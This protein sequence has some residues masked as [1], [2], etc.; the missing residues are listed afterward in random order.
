IDAR[1]EP[2]ALDEALA[3]LDEYLDYRRLAAEELSDPAL[4][5]SADLERRFQWI[6]ELRRRSFGAERAEALFAAEEEAVR[7]RLEVERVR[8]DETLEPE[9]RRRRLAELEARYPGPMRE[10]RAR[11]VSSLDWSRHEEAMRAQGF[12]PAEIHAAREARFGA[13]AAERM[14]ALDA[15]RADWAA[16]LE[17]YRQE[18]DVLLES[19]VDAEDARLAIDALRRRHFTAEEARRVEILDGA[20]TE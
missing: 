7:V 2:P 11:A 14:A 5:E 13:E 19:T 15:R 17:R 20:P 8:E 6:R 10:A 4:A 12:R 1:L 16:R 9:E 3:F 18:R